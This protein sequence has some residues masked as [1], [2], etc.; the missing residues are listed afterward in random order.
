MT[1][2]AAAAS[3]VKRTLPDPA[4]MPGWAA[5]RKEVNQAVSQVSDEDGNDCPGCKLDGSADFEAGTAKASF[6]ITT[7]AGTA[8]ASSYLATNAKKYGKNAS[9]LSVGVIGNETTAYSGTFGSSTGD[10]ILMRVGTTYAGVLLTGPSDVPKLQKMATM[11]ARRIEQT[12]SG[13]SA[14]AALDVT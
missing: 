3:T 7:F 4:S 6:K 2:S 9:P 10:L 11:L 12:A 5:H 1:G 13:E 14:N 8:E